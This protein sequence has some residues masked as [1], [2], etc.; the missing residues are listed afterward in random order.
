MSTPLK[1]LGRVGALIALALAAPLSADV[2]PPRLRAAAITFVNQATVGMPADNSATGKNILR[3]VGDLK[4]TLVLFQDGDKQLCLIT[5]PFPV[6]V[7]NLQVASRGIV[8]KELGL[9]VDAVV[10]ACSH[11]HTTPLITVKNP[12]AWAQPGAYPTSDETNE[13]GKQFFLALAETARGLH[14]K[15]APV[16]VE[17]GVAQE[18]RVTYNRRGRRP[19]GTSYFIREEDRVKLPPDYI[20][21]IDSD[22]MV[23]VLRGDDH[24]PVAALGFFSGHPVTGYNPEYPIA[25][26]QWP[27]VAC[28]KLS[29]HLGG[30]PVAFI[31]GCAGDINSKYL[32]TGTVEQAIE[33]GNF[34]GDS[35]IKASE[36][37]HISQRTGLA[38]ERPEVDI[39][40]A[41][42]PSVESLKKDLAS[43]DDFIARGRKGDPNTMFCVGMNFPEALT[44]LYRA[45]LVQM[46]RPW[47]VWALDQRQSN[48]TASLPKSV[49]LHVVVA[50]IGDVGFVGMPWEAFSRT[51]HLLKEKSPLPF[52]LTATYVDG[53]QGYIPDATAVD[54]REY[55]AGYFRYLGTRPP[56]KAPAGDAVVD[57]AIPVLAK[58]AR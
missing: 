5:S 25:F 46:V 6:N 9:P 36:N 19:D 51:A 35:F 22:A 28:E 18:T 2:T 10:T 54:D 1:L 24:K 57:V 56:Y 21:L 26:G 38:W 58:L 37:L 30:V 23:V 50:R 33:L 17:W 41:E 44:P 15:L 27:Q 49:P 55:Q 3:V 12:Q 7:G 13:L 39:P 34:L 40:L 31:Q 8:A 16:T 14:A 53:A 45:Q 48:L 42:L 4:S 20:G 52:L 29:A 47:Y 43:I 32:L 11:D